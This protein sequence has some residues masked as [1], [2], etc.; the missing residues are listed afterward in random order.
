MDNSWVEIAGQPGDAG[1]VLFN[2]PNGSGSAFTE[3]RTLEDGQ[4][5]A[6]ITLYLRDSDNVPIANYP[7]EDTWLAYIITDTLGVPCTSGTT[8]DYDTDVNGETTWVNPLR[9]GGWSEGPTV[10]MIAGSPLLSG[11]LN[12]GH[13]S[14]DINGNGVVNLQ[15]VALFAGDLYGGGYMFRSDFHYD[16]VVNLSDVGKLAQSLGAACP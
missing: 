2:V 3:A 1:R 10:V 13:N 6:T 12:L 14:A 16:G 7:R 5:D 11:D 15:D 4:V 8:A 9:A